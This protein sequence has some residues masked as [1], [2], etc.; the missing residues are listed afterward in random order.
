MTREYESMPCPRCK[1][2]EAFIAGTAGKGRGSVYAC[3]CGWRGYNPQENH[4]REAF[5][6][7]LLAD[8]ERIKNGGL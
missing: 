6:E 8:Q 3:G 4:L 2:K 5:A 1:M 7:R